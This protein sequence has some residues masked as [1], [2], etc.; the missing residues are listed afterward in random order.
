MLLQ[1]NGNWRP[2]SWWSRAINPGGKAYSSTELEFKALH[3]ILYAETEREKGNERRRGR[4]PARD[5]ADRDTIINV[6]FKPLTKERKMVSQEGGE[7]QWLP[8][9]ETSS[10]QN[11]QW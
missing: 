9:D 3:S 6:G 4:V 8:E 10:H 1:K 11:I 5:E 2:V 7:S